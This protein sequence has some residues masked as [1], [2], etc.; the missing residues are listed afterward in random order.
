MHRQDTAS[1]EEANSG[2]G[3][4]VLVVEDE[5]LI[6]LGICDHLR[7][8]GYQ[9]T[10]AAN[11]EEASHILLAGLAVDFLFTDIQ[12]PGRVDGIDLARWVQATRP[13]IR[14]ILTSGTPDVS[15]KVAELCAGAAFVAKPYDAQAVEQRIRNALGGAATY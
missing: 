14:I 5:V 12:M 13:N 2:N 7:D 8:C 15:A 11:A 6:R 1:E 10:E 9:V 4:R 3:W